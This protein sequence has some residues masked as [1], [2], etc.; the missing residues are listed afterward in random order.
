[1]VNISS[2]GFSAQ[3]NIE[4][5]KKVQS[6]QKNEVQDLA[7]SAR[8][9]KRDC[10]VS[11]KDKEAAKEVQDNKSKSI[12]GM[13]KIISGML[14]AVGAGAVIGAVANWGSKLTNQQFHFPKAPLSPNTSAKIGVAGAILAGLF[15]I[16]NA[17]NQAMKPAATDGME[18][19]L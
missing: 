17:V 8:R 13:N 3:N 4:K 16:P 19:K 18:Y 6:P 7:F 12:D 1:M 9:C 11:S 14:K 2:V 5:G 10:Y 15:T